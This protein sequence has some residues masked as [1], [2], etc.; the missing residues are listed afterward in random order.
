MPLA[1]LWQP[2]TIASVTKVVAKAR[3][4]LILLCIALIEYLLPIG[5]ISKNQLPA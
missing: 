1:F 3:V 4:L 5:S 2:V